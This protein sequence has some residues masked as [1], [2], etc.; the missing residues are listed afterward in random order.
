MAEH[1]AHRFCNSMPRRTLLTS[2]SVGMIQ[3][4]ETEKK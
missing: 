1:E 4:T 3:M 2:G